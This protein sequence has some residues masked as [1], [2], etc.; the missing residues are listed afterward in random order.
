MYLSKIFI[1]SRW[2]RIKEFCSLAIMNT[3]KGISCNCTHYIPLSNGTKLEFKIFLEVHEFEI[4]ND[5]TIHSTETLTEHM[6]TLYTI[7]WGLKLHS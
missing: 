1:N 6:E 3:G 4:V 2:V 5:V 7:I